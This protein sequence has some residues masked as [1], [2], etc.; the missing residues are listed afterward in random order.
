VRAAIGQA[1]RS[2]PATTPRTSKRTSAP[3]PRP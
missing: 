3:P 2:S 1:P